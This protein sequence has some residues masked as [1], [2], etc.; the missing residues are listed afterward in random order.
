SVTAAVAPFVAFTV[1][2]CST[3]VPPRTASANA[4]EPGDSP[5]TTM[6]AAQAHPAASAQDGPS[7]VIEGL[8]RALAAHE[9]TR[10]RG[11]LDSNMRRALSEEK[12]AE[13]WRGQASALGALKSIQPDAGVERNGKL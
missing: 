4:S 11:S 5:A 8:F 6:E 3:Q 1:L 13:V 9:F 2:S 10:A 7:G 12:L